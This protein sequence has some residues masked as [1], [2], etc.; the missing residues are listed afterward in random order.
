MV[1]NAARS[2]EERWHENYDALKAYVAEHHQMP[3]KKKAEHRNLL[4][5]WKYNKKCVK[6]DKLDAEKLKLLQELSDM[7]TV[8][9]MKFLP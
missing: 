2:R 5:W 8:K 3:D 6:Q 7:R 1:L 4:N 9:A